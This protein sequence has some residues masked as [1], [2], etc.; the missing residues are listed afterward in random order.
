MFGKVLTLVLF[1]WYKNAKFGFC[2]LE[3]LYFLKA[4][5]RMFFRLTHIQYR[6]KPLRPSYLLA[7][8]QVDRKVFDRICIIYN[9]ELDFKKSYIL[10]LMAG[11]RF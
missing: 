9:S 6:L 2:V 3:T 10:F 8:S 7:S 4:S 11:E 1:W 5:L